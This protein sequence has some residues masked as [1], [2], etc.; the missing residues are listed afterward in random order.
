MMAS[1][2]VESEPELNV[3]AGDADADAEGDETRGGKKLGKRKHAQ[4]G[5]DELGPKKQKT[6]HESKAKSKVQAEQKSHT[7]VGDDFFGSDDD[8]E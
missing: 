6:H 2:E 1:G 4:V 8:A 5:G 7:V 3:G